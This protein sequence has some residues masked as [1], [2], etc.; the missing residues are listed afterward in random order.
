MNNL[1]CY[2]IRLSSL[3]EREPIIK[4]LEKDLQKVIFRFDAFDGQYYRNSFLNY[5]H[6]VNNEKINNG[7]IGCLLSHTGLLEIVQDTKYVIFEDDC[8][9]VSTLDD[10]NNFIKSL[11]EYDLVCLSASE[12]VSYSSTENSSIVSIKRF[13]GSH[14]LILTQK[15][16][17]RIIETFEKYSEKKIFLPADWLYSIAIQEHNLKCYGPTNSKEFFKQTSGL[18]SSINGKIRQ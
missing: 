11:P 1:N 12:Y 10:T 9:C 13:H 2:S 5:K 15:A 4:N 16:V 3:K 14:A 17:E 18:V 8:E 6:V 7:M